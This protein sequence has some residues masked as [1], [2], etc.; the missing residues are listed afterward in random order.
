MMVRA[1]V[2]RRRL[3]THHSIEH[4]AQRHAIHDGALHIKAHNAPR[5]LVITTSTS[6]MG[7]VRLA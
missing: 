1:E 2:A 3:A 4:L 7:P 6:G 5:T